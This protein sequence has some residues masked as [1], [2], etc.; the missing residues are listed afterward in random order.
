MIRLSKLKI[1]HKFLIIICLVLLAGVSTLGLGKFFSQI[2]ITQS[3]YISEVKEAN[4]KF[5]VAMTNYSQAFVSSIEHPE[6][7][8]TGKTQT[9]INYTA[10]LEKMR[11]L[12]AKLV[13]HQLSSELSINT[14]MLD[15]LTY[16]TKI[17]RF[18]LDI[19]KKLKHRGNFEYGILSALTV[20]FNQVLVAT[21]DT[22]IKNQL[23]RL[24][25]IE[26]EYILQKEPLTVSDFTAKV[27]RMSRIIRSDSAANVSQIFLGRLDTYYLLFKQLV[28]IDRQIGYTTEDGLRTKLL[29]HKNKIDQKFRTL[30]GILDRKKESSRNSAFGAF[31]LI[32][33]LIISITLFAIWL[34]QLS[35]LKPIDLLKK[36]INRI[37]TGHLPKSEILFTNEDELKDI[38]DIINQVV[39]GLR[40]ATSF[41]TAIGNSEFTK[42]FTPLG[43]EDQLGNSLINMRNS[44]QNAKIE[45]NKR[46]IEDEKRRWISQGINKFS[47][48]LRQRTN[49][50]ELSYNIIS[51]LVEYMDAKIGGIFISQKNSEDKDVLKL[52]ASFAYDRQKY[53]ESTVLMGEGLIGSCALEMQTVHIKKVPDNY[54]DISSGFGQ[55]QPSQLVFI[56]LITDEKLFGVLEIA[57]F[58]KFEDFQIKF[59]EEIAESIASTLQSVNTNDQTSQ[60]LEQS[61][62]Q[63]DEMSAQEEEMRQNLEELQA[64]QEESARRET[65][66]AGIISALDA[67]FLVSEFSIDGIYTHVNEMF[68]ETIGLRNEQIAGQHISFLNPKLSSTN[69]YEK[70]WND[71]LKGKSV[72]LKTTINYA[73]QEVILAENYTPICDHDDVPYKILN[74]ASKLIK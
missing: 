68:E 43:T 6:F 54:I 49:L 22:T 74:I 65:E 38:G 69:N 53:I 4:L 39:S 23:Y 12:I 37:K 66:L 24:R 21:N 11:S 31:L 30:T 59:A 26:Y 5:N 18:S 58:N 1:K 67:L 46:S 63:S 32:S 70:L 17:E 10:M 56:P 73:G 34:F 72:Q 64:T 44:L 25:Q 57:T 3:N 29:T 62:L 2:L 14:H 55:A 27:R 7:F 41:A 48:L 20:K 61:Q 16:S 33:I 47:D 40:S 52:I 19:L 35:V 71:L 28:E 45:E 9:I 15:I 50:E 36:H 60:L 8:R 13:E 51:E 42:K